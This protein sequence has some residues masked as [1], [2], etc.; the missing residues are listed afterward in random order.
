MLSLVHFIVVLNPKIGS[1][2]KI[3][4]TARVR[5]EAMLNAD[6]KAVTIEITKGA[7]VIFSFSYTLQ[8]V[9]LQT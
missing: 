7:N 2:N 1:I 9:S 3:K 5:I 8:Q 6:L 4:S